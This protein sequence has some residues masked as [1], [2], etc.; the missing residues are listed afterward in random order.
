LTVGK[1]L[2]QTDER[3]KKKDKKKSLGSNPPTKKG[4]KENGWS[5]T[6]T[7]GKERG[8]GGAVVRETVRKQHGNVQGHSRRGR[9]GIEN[10]SKVF[11]GLFW[12]KRGIAVQAVTPKGW[13]GGTYGG[14]SKKRW[15]GDHPFKRKRKEVGVGRGGGRNKGREQV[16]R[17][18]INGW[19]GREKKKGKDSN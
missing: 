10:G 19:D 12:G 16:S 2:K 5:K 8:R 6:P 13:K 4:G 18:A 9:W 15:G 1:G 11:F 3:A 14:R 17:E 7:G